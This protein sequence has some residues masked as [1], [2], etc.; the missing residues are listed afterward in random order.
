MMEAGADIF[1]VNFSHGDYETHQ[2]NLEMV[3]SAARDLQ[4]NVAILL[5][6]QGIKVR[7]TFTRSGPFELVEGSE[8]EIQGGEEA[9]DSKRIS[10]APRE[11]VQNLRPGD[12]VLIDDGRIRLRVLQGRGGFWTC[13]VEVGGV[14][15][16]RK[17]VHLPDTPTRELPS[18]TPKD[19]KDL[20]WAIGH[21][22]DLI[23]LSFVRSRRDII[24]VK[25]FLADRGADIPVI[26]KIEKPE[27]FSE[28]E[29]VLQ[30]SY[31]V[32]VA[33]GD[34][35]VEMRLEKVPLMQKKII[36]Q[37]RS[38]MKPAITA[39]QM[40][41]S[42]M[43]R[44]I[45]T[46]AEVSDVANAVF[47]G[48]DAVMLSGE[49]AVGKYPIETVRMMG[50]IVAEADAEMLKTRKTRTFSA[51]KA[52]FANAVGEAAC[53]AAESVGAKCIVV[54]T[55]SG[56]SAI[57]VSGRRPAMPVFAFG[58]H[59]KTLRRLALVWGVETR[60]LHGTP[61]SVEGLIRECET[62]L[63]QESAVQEGDSA[64][65]VAGMPFVETGNTNFLKLH[66]VG[67]LT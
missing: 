52:P 30:E 45:P 66:R 34:L 49:T 8:I 9:S 40:L 16:D 42:M 55:R 23:A 44:P 26:A 20:E 6:L 4:H 2:K 63:L 43:E 7:T 33:R 28:L 56:Y 57:L 36:A 59:E 18:L 38:L 65:M 41:E 39:T 32:M 61:T 51:E 11:A 60:L 14:V 64:V 27:V 29:G 19:L 67:R 21:G 37:A 46:R 50:Q 5:D 17:G 3:R 12:P 15:K 22:V 25:K 10:I 62:T 54:Y 1:R 53:V 13:R 47:D 24:E 35:G 58:E 31:G 48:T